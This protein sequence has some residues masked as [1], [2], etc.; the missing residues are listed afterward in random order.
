MAVKEALLGILTLGPA[1]GLQL[2]FELCSRAPHR[3]RTNVGQIYGTL[4]R[5]S[6]AGMV[7]RAGETSD[8]LPLYALTSEGVSAAESWLRA[9]SVLTLTEWPELLD[10]ILIARSLSDDTLESVVGV[11]EQILTEDIPVHDRRSGSS[12]N[13]MAAA[14]EHFRNAALAWLGDVRREL[15]SRRSNTQNGT[16]FARDDSGEEAVPHGYLITRPKRGRPALV[17]E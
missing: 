10:H 2:H 8:G 3:E 11:Y 1:Y 4:E 16:L 5:L 7:L 12:V 14:N 9:E 17:K 13:I 6:V 15:S